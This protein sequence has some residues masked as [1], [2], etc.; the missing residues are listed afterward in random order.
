MMTDKSITETQNEVDIS[1]ANSEFLAAGV[2]IYKTLGINREFAIACMK[3]LA[4]RRKNGEDFNYEEF[5][6]EEINKIPK[7]SNSD[8]LKVSKSLLEK[9]IKNPLIK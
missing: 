5:I 7:I 4:N 2:V 3:E 8:Y 1:S 9:K 6:E